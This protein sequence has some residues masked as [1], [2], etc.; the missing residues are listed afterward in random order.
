[1]TC[2]S[3]I[4]DDQFGERECA[5]VEDKAEEVPGRNSE[6]ERQ[7]NRCK[8]NTDISLRLSVSTT[9]TNI[10]SNCY[11]HDNYFTRVQCL[12]AKTNIYFVSEV[13]TR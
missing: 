8:Y 9:Q 12:Q 4:T 7:D 13:D 10:K 3:C 11:F 6:T 5:T 1:M 2:Y